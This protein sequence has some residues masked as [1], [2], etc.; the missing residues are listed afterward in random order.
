[1]TRYALLSAALLLAACDTPTAPRT[2]ATAEA[3]SAEVIGSA[4]FERQ[5]IVINDCNGDIFEID[6]KF[7]FLTA[8]TYDGAGGYHV[9]L[10]SNISGKGTNLAT[11]AVYVISQEENNVYTVGNGADE[12]THVLQFN[13]IGQGAVPDEVLLANFH[14]TFTPDGGVSGYHDNFMI[15]CD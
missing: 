9:T 3:L 4:H 6:A 15:K 11:G 10:H 13:M 8:V 12:Q 1:M 14:I 5:A 2:P 7:H